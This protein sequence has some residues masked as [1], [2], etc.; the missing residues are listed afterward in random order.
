MLPQYF[1]LMGR[2]IT[3]HLQSQ[4]EYSSLNENCH[5]AEKLEC[6]CFL[7]NSMRTQQ[8]SESCELITYPG[9]CVYKSDS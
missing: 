4:I 5:L 7:F 1:F 2:K 8:D 6:F 9:P 3:P